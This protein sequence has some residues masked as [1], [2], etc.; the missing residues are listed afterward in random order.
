MLL[1]FK[2]GVAKRASCR[3]AEMRAR[4]SRARAFPNRHVTPIR[5]HFPGARKPF[6]PPPL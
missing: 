5:R 2:R 6:R 3:G 4:G 1:A